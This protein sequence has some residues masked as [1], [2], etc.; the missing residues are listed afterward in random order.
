MEE[1]YRKP[2]VSFLTSFSSTKLY[3]RMTR[4]LATK[5]RGWDGWKDTHWGLP[6]LRLNG[7]WD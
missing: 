6:W 4:W 7:L 1:M 2:E 3:M 5:N